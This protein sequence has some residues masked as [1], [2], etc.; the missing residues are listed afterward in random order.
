MLGRY[1]PLGLAAFLWV[2]VAPLVRALRA[3]RAQVDDR[4]RLLILGVMV[5]A[6]AFLLHG[7]LDS[8]LAFT[9]T[10]LLFWALLGILLAQ[11]P[12]VSGRW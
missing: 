3:L 12:H 2:I 11:K 6:S 5:S 10:A 9:P 7:L 1:A 8:F 4:Q